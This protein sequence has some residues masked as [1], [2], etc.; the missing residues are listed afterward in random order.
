MF[1][2]KSFF[3]FVNVYPMK[4]MLL[5]RIVSLIYLLRYNEHQIPLPFRHINNF[6]PRP[7]N[8]LAFLQS[9]DLDCYPLVL[10]PGKKEITLKFLHRYLQVAEISDSGVL[11]HRKSNPYDREFELLI[12]PIET[13]FKKLWGRYFFAINSKKFIDGC[14]ESCSLC[15]SLKSL[16][17][18]LF[19]QSPSQVPETIEVFLCRHYSTRKTKEHCLTRCAFLISDGGGGGGGGGGSRFC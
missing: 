19:K 1:H 16:P 7:Q 10:R 12:V 15:T 5:L 17:R 3:S 11:I 4:K 9:Y 8:L 13:Q 14:T 2:R 6:Y 18:E